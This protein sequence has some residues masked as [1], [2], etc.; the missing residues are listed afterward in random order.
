MQIPDAKADEIVSYNEVIEHL[1]RQQM[2]DDLDDS[3]EKIWRFRQITSHEAPCLET[4]KIT[5]DAN[6]MS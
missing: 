2:Q 4:I 3:G 5:K 6:T 1:T